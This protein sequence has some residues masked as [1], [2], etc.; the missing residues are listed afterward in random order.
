VDALA[1]AAAIL[2]MAAIISGLL[3]L[4]YMTGSPRVALERRLGH[5]LGE[6]TGFEVTPVQSEALREKRVGHVPLI[7]GLIEGRSWTEQLAEDL[8]RGDLRLTVAEFIAIRLFMALGG[9]AIPVLLMG[10]MLRYLIALGLGFVGFILPMVFLRQ[11][12]RRR[13][14]KLDSQLVDALSMLANSL[15]AGFGL[16]QSM[17]LISKELDHPIATEMR[18]TLSD[19]NVGS[20]T[21][22]SLQ[23]LAKRS[24]SAD[25][26]I[27]I[28][29]MLIQQSTGGN[30]A[31]ILEN[32]GHTMR[33]RIRIRGEIKTLTTQQVLTGVIIGALPFVIAGFINVLNPTYMEPLYTELAGQVMLGGALMMEMFGIF[34]IKRILDIEV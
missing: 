25:L 15:K 21:E 28:T 26:D 6:S 12:Q 1:V 2:V 8:E 7:S 27:V 22:E 30:L 34:L 10:G 17:D 19:I 5:V 3:G 11:A 29:A 4:Y 20:T 9:V 13:V 16:I 32:V 24:G 33:E 18:R 14:A 23:A 31:E